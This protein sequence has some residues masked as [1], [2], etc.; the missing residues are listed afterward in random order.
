MP[1][2][3]RLTQS[4]AC[5][6]CGAYGNS[7]HGRSCQPELKRRFRLEFSRVARHDD[8]ISAALRDRARLPPAQLRCE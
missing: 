5:A 7:Q 2:L 1:A 6:S 8:H 4:G 3:L